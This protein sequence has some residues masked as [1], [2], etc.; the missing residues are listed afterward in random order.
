MTRTANSAY[1]AR[2]SQTAHSTPHLTLYFLQASRSI[3]VAWL[4][5]LL[6]LPYQL[7]SS[8][9][10][11]N[12]A[13]AAFKEASG[14]R[15]GKFPVLRDAQPNSED[16]VLF[17]SGAI[18]ESLCDRFDLAGDL[19]PRAEEGKTYLRGRVLTFVH[20][21]EGMIMLHALAILYFR[22]NVPQAFRESS[23]GIEMMR[24]TERNMSVNVR[25]DFDWLEQELSASTGLYLVGNS[26]TAADVMMGFSVEFVIARQLGITREEFEGGN[27]VHEKEE[28][29]EGKKGETTGRGK[30]PRL[31]EWLERCH[32][33]ESWKRAVRRTGYTL[34][35]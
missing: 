17:E 35:T 5:E 7:E 23:E 33:T 21:A 4:L 13:P 30:W 6:E 8:P 12:K 34:D 26:V 25:N 1:H 11:S 16:V 22:W 28:K 15:L 32:G 2:Y 10:V 19:I 9:R 3:R 27:D 18:V 14:S 24:E 20:A 29:T 31:K